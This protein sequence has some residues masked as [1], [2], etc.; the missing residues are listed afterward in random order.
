MPAISNDAIISDILPTLDNAKDYVR[1]VLG[2]MAEYQKT[3]GSAFVRV[4]TTGRGI[5]P[6]Y[7]VQK[8]YAGPRPDPTAGEMVELE[9]MSGSADPSVY[10]TA[11]H[12]RSHKQL[13]WGSKELQ[14]EHWSTRAMSYDD[15]ATLLGNLRGFMKGQK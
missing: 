8:E 14:R 10:Y 6:H 11:F 9:V 12:G 1:R 7:R 4:G 3:H 2:N 5:A 13:E 15:V